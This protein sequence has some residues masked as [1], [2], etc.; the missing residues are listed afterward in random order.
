MLRYIQAT[1]RKK[2]QIAEK[3]IRKIIEKNHEKK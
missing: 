3:K 2:S 1:L